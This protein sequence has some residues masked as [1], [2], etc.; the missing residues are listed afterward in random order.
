MKHTCI[1]DVRS[2]EHDCYCE[3]GHDHTAKEHR[4][5]MGISA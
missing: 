4:E 1:A 5:A 2:P 3:I